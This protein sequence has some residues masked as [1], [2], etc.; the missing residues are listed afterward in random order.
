MPIVEYI[1]RLIPDAIVIGIVTYT[2]TVSLA[3]VFA[4]EFGYSINSN[5]VNASLQWCGIV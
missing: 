1:P 3:K 4:K 2:V 5:Q